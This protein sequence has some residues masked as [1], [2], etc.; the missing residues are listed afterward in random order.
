MAGEVLDLPKQFRGVGEVSRF[1]N[2]PQLVGEG[3]HL[4]KEFQ[5]VGEVLHFAK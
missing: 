1:A 4:A 5:V 2:Y 3:L